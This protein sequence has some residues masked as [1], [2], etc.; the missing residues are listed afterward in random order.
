MASES[1]ANAGSKVASG[2]GASP[3]TLSRADSRKEERDDG[4]SGVVGREWRVREV[5]RA[6]LLLV[7][8]L[9]LGMIALGGE[10]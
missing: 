9:E 5:E 10:W 8:R 4:R 3:V 7:S 6:R 1:S 2:K